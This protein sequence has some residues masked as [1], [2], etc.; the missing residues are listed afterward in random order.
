MKE[1][2]R[3]LVSD[4]E[5]KT[6]VY[7]WIKKNIP[8]TKKTKEIFGSGQDLV[9]NMEEAKAIDLPDIYCDMDSVLV[10]F[11]K[12][13]E[14][15]L[16]HD[17]TDHRYW[18]KKKDVDKRELLT[19]RDPHVYLNLEWMSDGK[20]LY[21]FINRYN[22]YI[23]SAYP[24][25]NPASRVDKVKWLKR[26][27]TVPRSKMFIVK[28]HEKRE[29]AISKSGQPNVLIDDHPKN[30]KEWQQA[31]GIGILHTSAANTIGKLK[32]IGF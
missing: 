11:L 5:L 7:D 28:R 32:A 17:F 15:V 10:D 30:I 18:G 29:Y 19:K 8:K 3:K 21:N 9:K 13:A 6:Q 2:G 4:S 12:K 27:T 16:G 14:E 26:N 1:P 24:D 23:L 20:K 22:P 31:G 25:W